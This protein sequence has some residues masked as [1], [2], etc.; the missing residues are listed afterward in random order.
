FEVER[1]VASG[2]MG[3]LYRARDHE[4]GGWVAFKRLPDGGDDARF[5]REIEVL[6]ALD[7]P[8]IVRYVAHGAGWLAMEWL[9]GEDLAARLLRAP[10]DVA[11]ATRLAERILEALAAA[12][13]AGVIHRDVKPANVF[14]VG[15]ETAAAKLL[16]FGVA[17]VN[18][19]ARGAT[20]TR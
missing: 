6:A 8:A 5:L 2:G 18:G 19:R 1:E 9:D 10:L 3:R 7:H 4:T 16:D 17:R 12:H 13:A 14:L 20:L 15:G 11:D